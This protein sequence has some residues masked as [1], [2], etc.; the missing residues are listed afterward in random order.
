MAGLCLAQVVRNNF[1]LSAYMWLLVDLHR[2]AAYRAAFPQ[3]PGK[4]T[5]H[6]DHDPR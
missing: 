2:I 3:Q 6:T 1:L 5:Y 4:H